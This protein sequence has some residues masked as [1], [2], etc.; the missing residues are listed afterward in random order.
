MRPEI[1]VDSLLQQATAEL[2]QSIQNWHQPD[3]GADHVVVL[4]TTAVGK[5][6]V[7]KAGAEAEVDA[8]VLARLAGHGIHVPALIAQAPLEYNPEAGS[9][10]VMTAVDGVLLADVDDHPERYLGSLI[11]QMRNV[12]AVTTSVGAGPVL[13]VEGGQGQSWRDY[14]VRMLTRQDPE[15]Q[16]SE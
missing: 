10:I 11:D 8:F 16:W 12:H 1:D 3:A 9:L 13:A 14:L 4:V 15:F 7:I 5:R 2:G 6:L